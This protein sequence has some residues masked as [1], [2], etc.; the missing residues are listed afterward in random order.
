MNK[1]HNQWDSIPSSV[2]QSK[3]HLS[4]F[5]KIVDNGRDDA[6]ENGQDG[7]DNFVCVRHSFIHCPYIINHPYSTGQS[8]KI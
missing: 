3:M 4:L 6:E 2:S 1:S 5:C 7:P 8:Y